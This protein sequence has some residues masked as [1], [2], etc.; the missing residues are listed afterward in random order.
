MELTFGQ[1]TSQSQMQFSVEDHFAAVPLQNLLDHTTR[2]IVESNLSLKAK[3]LQMAEQNGGQ[4]SAT[5]FY[6]EAD[7]EQ[8]QHL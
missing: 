8:M 2:R 7:T 3:I 5:L 6:K 4:L 1:H